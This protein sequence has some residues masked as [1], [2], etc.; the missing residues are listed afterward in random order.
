MIGSDVMVFKSVKVLIA[1]IVLS[2]GSAAIA[3]DL[4]N[5]AND[6][7]G[8]NYYYDAETIRRYSNNT[9][10]FWTKEDASKNKTETYSTESAK[11]RL[12]CSAETFGFIAFIEYREDGTV[13]KSRDYK[14]P[15]MR[16]IAP[17]TRIDRLF[18]II[19]SK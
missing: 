15:D 18:K 8:S 7:S 6:P 9:V 5:Y 3:E 16:S 11:L 2:L 19:C 4:V 14:Y 1:T 13:I 17:Q 10:E 12:D